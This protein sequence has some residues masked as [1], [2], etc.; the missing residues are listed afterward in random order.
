MTTKTTSVIGVEE[1]VQL[2]N[3]VPAQAMSNGCFIGH[4]ST[5]SYLMQQ[6]DSQGRLLFNTDSAAEYDI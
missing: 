3:L 4:Q 6:K 1:V 2:M 5:Y